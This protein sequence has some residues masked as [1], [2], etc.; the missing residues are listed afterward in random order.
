MAAAK[1]VQFKHHGFGEPPLTSR[2][3]EWSTVPHRP[4][5]GAME[6]S[7]QALHSLHE[8]NDHLST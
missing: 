1:A 5:A 3:N 4:V 6:L 2:V 7:G 8:P